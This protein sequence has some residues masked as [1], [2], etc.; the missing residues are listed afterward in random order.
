MFKHIM[1]LK[2]KIRQWGN[3]K[4]IIIPNEIDVSIGDVVSIEIS[5]IADL[6][7]VF[8]TIKTDV[9]GQK[10]KDEVKKGWK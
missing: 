1:E 7:D 8:G 4:G 5:K 10:F 6:T 3:S 2:T 9:T